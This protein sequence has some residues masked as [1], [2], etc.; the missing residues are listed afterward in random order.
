MDDPYWFG[1]I[2]AAN[3]LSDVYAMGASLFEMLSGRIPFQDENQTRL[4][5]KHVLD[6]VPDIT[7]IV[8]GLPAEMTAVITRAMAKDPNARYPTAGD[9]AAAVVSVSRGIPSRRAR[10]RWTSNELDSV[11]GALGDEEE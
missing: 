5:M 4:M 8:P 2:A 7:S 6:P 9:F 11:L 3:A 1:Q 10:K